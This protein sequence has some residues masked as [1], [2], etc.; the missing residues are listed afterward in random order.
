M[1]FA[2]N[3]IVLRS[4]RP[5][6]LDF[7]WSHYRALLKSLPEQLID[8]NDCRQKA[9]VEREVASGQA[10][11][12][13]AAGE[14]AG[15]L[16]VRE[17]E[18]TLELCQLYVAPALQSRGIGSAIVRRLIGEAQAKGKALTLEVLKNNRARLLYTRLGFV[19]TRESSLKIEM[20]W[21]GKS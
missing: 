14:E 19:Q 15:W 5:E 1:A 10:S 4:S 6:D 18:R 8:W 16:H 17:A 9:V 11:I 21:S 3:D 20:T 12:I 2:T 7:A 13:L